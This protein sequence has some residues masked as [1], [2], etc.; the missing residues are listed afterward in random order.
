MKRSKGPPGLHIEIQLATRDAVPPVRRWLKQH[1]QQVAVHAGVNIGTLTVRIV[2]DQEMTALHEAFKHEAT[3]TDVLTFDLRDE[4][5]DPHAPLEGDLVLCMDEAHRQGA[6]R[7]H[8]T[9]VELL[10]YAVHGLLHLLGYDDQ[11]PTQFRAM[12]QHEDQ[13]LH[14]I[15]L[16]PVFAAKPPGSKPRAGAAGA[17]DCSRRKCVAGS[18][19]PASMSR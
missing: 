3:T 9:R 1:L 5:A 19:V 2:D 13:L 7:G 12:H 8:A 6:A 17:G 15:G 16:A 4:P 10:L 14:A 11:T 18:P